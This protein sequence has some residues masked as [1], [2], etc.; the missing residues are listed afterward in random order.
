MEMREE[1]RTRAARPRLCR[2]GF[3][4]A[5]AAVLA[6]S[7][8]PSR[9]ALAQDSSAAAP[10]A[11][12]FDIAEGPVADALDRFARQA[13][14]SVAYDAAGM[15]GIRSQALRGRYTVPEGLQALLAGTGL[16]ARASSAGYRVEPLRGG[17]VAALAPVEV[18]GR[19]MGE[20][21]E[22]TG[23]YTTGATSAAT[24]LGLSLRET[25]QSVTVITRQRLDDQ[26]LNSLGRAVT[27]APGVLS[28]PTGAGVG[29]YASIYARG[30]QLKSYQID[31]LVTPTDA[32]SSNGLQ[33][34]SS[35]DTAIYDSITVVRGAAGLLAGAGDPA[36]SVSLTRK[37]PTE[38]FQA[39]LAQSLGSWDQ[40]RTVAD[41][42]GPLNEAG[43]LRARV[44]GAYDEG[45]SWQDRYGYTRHVAY[46]VLEA[47]L[48]ERTMLTLAFERTG[49]N[50]HG[51]GAYTGFDMAFSDGTRTPFSR[52]D[53][54]LTDWSRYRNRHTG[55]SLGLEHRFSADWQAKLLYSHNKYHERYKSGYAGVGVP[56][57][58]GFSDLSF[59]ST[60]QDTRVDALQAQ[61]NGR[62]TLWGR[63]HD[64]VVGIN[65]SS[66]RV[67]DPAFGNDW[68]ADR[69][70]TLT[71]QGK[72][73]EPD[74]DALESPGS[75]TKTT[76]SGMWL[77]TRLRATDRLSLI[78]GTRWS[79]WKIHEKDMETGEVYDARKEHGVFTP[80]AGLVYDFAEQYS[81]YASYTEIFNPQS[82]QDADGR[83]L[84]P[85]EGKNYE[86]GLKGEWLDG[87]L[88]AS[89]AAFEVRKD[90]L[91]VQDG[92]RLTPTGDQAYAAT[93]HTKG[94]GFELE[95]AGE[96]APGWHVQG[97]YTRM[98]TRDSDGNR[99]NA[100]LP[101]HLFKLFATWTPAG[102]NR[103]TLG[104]GVTWQSKIYADWDPAFRHIY[105]QKSYA[106]VY[107]MGRYAFNDHLS[108]LVNV[109]NVFDRSY[110]TDTS[111]HDYGPPRN[112]YAT[113]KYQ[114]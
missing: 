39:S 70:Q 95:I 19:R 46:G 29:G 21:T 114:F 60:E 35:L 57:P 69:V 56:D 109:D 42:G 97:G 33:G 86:L 6:G 32:W 92:N 105:T 88:N 65:G 40:R 78:A 37:R 90:N 87:R 84:D 52:H 12:A 71:W 99:L 53:N 74:W 54:A 80:Y 79:N 93:D 31:G 101:K 49:Q 38:D 16:R 94:R 85:E 24:G 89:L 81:A 62:Y 1:A 25:P 113:L 68:E 5:L 3:A 44:V 77:A 27:Q 34:N 104:G 96:L 48:S 14:V 72:Y 61:V 102:L 73:P 55:A 36:G 45:G 2:D 50:G 43:T 106:V 103:L 26:A 108:L 17:D 82:Y 83:T 13:G 91:A 107:L 18:T 23:S 7:L 8:A 67:R 75:S 4:V 110:R 64:L 20:A 98:V 30:F 59:R 111:R 100:D 58:D 51:A 76:Q 47:D 15:R 63:R 112:I 41:V 22:G 66:S 28:N 11:V 10:A 9:A